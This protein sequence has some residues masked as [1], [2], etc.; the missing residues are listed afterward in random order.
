MLGSSQS[1]MQALCRE[2]T[3]TCAPRAASRS[4]TR[5]PVV[6]V[7]PVT[8]VSSRVMDPV[9]RSASRRAIV[10]TPEDMRERLGSASWTPWPHC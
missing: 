6:P 5:R 1:S 8:N 9:Q 4:T 2:A 3:R 10:E 7:P